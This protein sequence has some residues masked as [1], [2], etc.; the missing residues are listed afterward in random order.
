VLKLCHICVFAE[1][2]RN[3]INI[4]GGQRLSARIFAKILPE[5]KNDYFFILGKK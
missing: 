3:L 2:A 4:F 5:N 1:L